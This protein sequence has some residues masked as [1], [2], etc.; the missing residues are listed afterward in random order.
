[1]TIYKE[2]VITLVCDKCGYEVALLPLQDISK[3]LSK[4]N[5]TK[6]EDKHFCPDCKPAPI[7]II[8]PLEAALNDPG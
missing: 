5:W 7:P 4:S 6:V 8:C 3:W 2:N 1:M